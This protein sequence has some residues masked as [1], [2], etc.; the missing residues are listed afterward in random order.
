LPDPNKNIPSKPNLGDYRSI[1]SLLRTH[2]QNHPD[3]PFLEFVE[4]G[5]VLTYQEMSIIAEQFARWAHT[6]NLKA[7]DRIL[8]LSENSI[9]NLALFFAFLSYGVTYCAINVEVNESHISEMI[10]RL[11]P[12]L[13]LYDSA[14]PFEMFSPQSVKKWIPI[15]EF[16]S[17]LKGYEEGPLPDEV[18]LPENTAVITFTSGTSEAPKGVIHTFGNYYW[19]AQQTINMWKLTGSDKILEYRSIS[20]ASAH[21]LTLIPTIVTGGTIL[22]AKR[23]SQTHFSDWIASHRPTMI[24]GVPTVINI[25]LSGEHRSLGEVFSGVRFISCS[26]APLMVKQH[27]Q[28]EKLY[29]IELVQIYGM[30]EGGVVAGNH[31][32]ERRIGSVGRPGLYQ[33]L[34][35]IGLDG[36]KMKPGQ[37]G[38]IEIG[39]AQTGY[40]YLHADH[41]IEIIQNK[42]LKTGDLGYLDEEGFLYITGREKDLIIRG[43]VNIA[44]LEID[45]IICQHPAV[46]ETAS[47]GVPD[48]VYG[49]GIVCYIV[50]KPQQ[51]IT[52]KSLHN[53]CDQHLTMIKRPTDFVIIEKIPLNDRG[54]V[55]RNALRS[56]WS[57]LNNKVKRK[58]P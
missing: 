34:K 44:P 28:F 42:R 56:R 33:N 2:T 4:D 11:N 48:P 40:G 27:K 12:S 54:K 14:K 5:R 9:E 21:M 24:I 58:V 18:C 19:I 49:E 20:W 25:L 50:P 23:F 10:K 41:T 52:K 17:T 43:G 57:S 51:S 35:I 16:F 53:F 30:S 22:F 26:T 13:I 39:G 36:K 46:R 6:Q 29:G 45:N 7:N 15:D 31:A 1:R 3:K 38:E 37:I 8:V 47:I 55:D 32:G